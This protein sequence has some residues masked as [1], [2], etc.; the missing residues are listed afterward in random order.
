LAAGAI[1]WVLLLQI[2]SDDATGMYWGDLGRIYVWIRKDDL[3]HGRFDAAWL[4]LQ[5]S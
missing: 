2:D 3:R 1:D 5:C 4:V